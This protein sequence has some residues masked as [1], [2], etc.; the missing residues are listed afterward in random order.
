MKDTKTIHPIAVNEVKAVEQIRF[1]DGTFNRGDALFLFFYLSFNLNNLNNMK[2]NYKRNWLFALKSFAVFGALLFVGTASA[3]LN[4]TYTI[5]ASTGD[6]ASFAELQ[7]T[8]DSDG[9][10]G[11]V[12]INVSSATYSESFELNDITGSSA[13]NTIR[14]NGGDA[15]ITSSS[16]ETINIEDAKYIIIKDLRI[17]S[18][19]STGECMRIQGNTSNIMVDSSEFIKLNGSNVSS[20][21]VYLMISEG[22]TAFGNGLDEKTDIVISNNHFH[23]GDPSSLFTGAYAG[24]AIHQDPN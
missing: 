19:S 6:F 22:T 9:I 11:A 12:V 24:I 5:D 18:T 3:Q 4:G 23:N 2:K 13:T 1:I 8:L 7:D 17:R 14:I 20:G 15:L 21:S 16:L 10:S